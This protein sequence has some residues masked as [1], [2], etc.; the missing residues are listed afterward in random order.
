MI[1]EQF[2]NLW[3]GGVHVRTLFVDC[4]FLKNYFQNYLCKHLLNLRVS[5][6]KPTLSFLYRKKDSLNHNHVNLSKFLH[7]H[8][9]LLEISSTLVLIK[10]R[11]F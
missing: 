6:I 1:S 7:K 4:R 3:D 8:G 9:F 2:I 11:L 5:C 10:A